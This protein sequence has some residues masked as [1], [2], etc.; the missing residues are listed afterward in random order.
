M[1]RNYKLRNGYNYVELNI[2]VYKSSFG[3]QTE[4][5]YFHSCKNSLIP[6]IEK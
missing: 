6:N 1:R 4:K 2:A 3:M 5:K